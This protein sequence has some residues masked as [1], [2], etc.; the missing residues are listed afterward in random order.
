MSR[1]LKFVL[2]ANLLALAVLAFAYP[3][4]M[5]APG[6]LIPG[7]KQLEPDCFACHAPLLGAASERCITC[8]KTADIG[9]LTTKGLPVRKPLTSTPFHQ[10]LVNTDCVACHSDHSGV[11]RFR[12]QGRFNHA[13]L[14]KE[15]LSQCQSCHKLPADSLHRQISG[16]CSQCHNQNKWT[17]ATFDHDKYF[18]LDRDHNARCVTCHEG[19]NYSRY[20]CYGC[21]EHSPSSIRREHIEE[22][23]RNFNNCV[24]CH[25][26]ADEH[27]GGKGGRGEGDDD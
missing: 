1:T 4:L 27:E 3:H 22:G 21:H 25:R 12:E 10:K 20:T 9:R 17:P 8:H 26:S 18:V 13:L 15:T 11:K 2:A 16:N 19:S 14:Q 6:K 24:K 7:H 23:I 5:V